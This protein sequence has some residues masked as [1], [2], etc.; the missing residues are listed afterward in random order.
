M[1]PKNIYS[2]YIRIN[3]LKLKPFSKKCFMNPKFDK[4]KGDTRKIWKT[5]GSLLPS[6][7]KSSN[8]PSNSNN[9]SYKSQL[10]EKPENFNNFFCSIGKNLAQK[11]STLPT[12]RFKSYLKNRVS[13]SIF[14]EPPNISEIVALMQAPDVNKAV[15]HDNIPAFF[16][17]VSKVVIAPYLNILIAFAFS[18]RIFPDSCKTAKDIPLLKSGNVND[19]NSYRPISIL[20]YFS[21]IFEKL[22]H[23][24]LSEFLNKNNVII[25]TQYGFQINFSTSHAI[26]DIITHAYDNINNN[27]FTGLFF[28]DLKKAFDTVNHK[29]LEFKLNHYGICVCVLNLKLSF[30][31][32]Y[33]YIYIN[34]ISS[35]TKSN[36]YGVP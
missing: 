12:N 27:Q 34:G 17:K 8:N 3:I 13:S 2:S 20:T 32:R 1:K 29:I 30:L 31:E 23:K 9:C 18:N 7:N 4:N 35:T 16:I 11:I 5:I 15:G 36:P 22:L 6:K 10:Q 26:L 14:L 21:K 33:Q 24:R 19:P 25:P 28:L